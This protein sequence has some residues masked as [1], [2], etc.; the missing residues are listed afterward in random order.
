MKVWVR[1]VVFFL[2]AFYTHEKAFF[3]QHTIDEFTQKNMIK[4]IRYGD[5][6][7]YTFKKLMNNN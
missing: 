1:N 2:K 3:F 5:C 6:T 4:K 7:S